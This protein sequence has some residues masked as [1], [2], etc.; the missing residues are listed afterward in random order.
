MSDFPA[1]FSAKFHSSVET[2]KQTDC[3]LSA[4]AGQGVVDR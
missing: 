3:V 2:R 1:D 4:L